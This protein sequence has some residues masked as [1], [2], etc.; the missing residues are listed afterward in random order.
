M[1][2]LCV[3]WTVRAQDSPSAQANSGQAKN[4]AELPPL[5]DVE[6]RLGPFSVRDENFTVVVHEKQLTGARDAL[7]AQTLGT[8][9]IL[10]SKGPVAYQRIFKFGAGEGRFERSLTASARLL[11]GKYFTGLL[12]SYRL[13]LASRYVSKRSEVISTLIPPW[14]LRSSS[15]YFRG[16]LGKVNCTLVRGK[17]IESVQ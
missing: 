6:Q 2:L 15:G 13:R 14:N 11:S 5:E 16:R 17:R 3:A 7:F 1:A 4:S 9:E 8:L 10:D 12:I